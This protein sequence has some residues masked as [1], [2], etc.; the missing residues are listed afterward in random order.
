MPSSTTLKWVKLVAAT[1]LALWLAFV[2]RSASAQESM[3][4]E[5]PVDSALQIQELQD[6]LADNPYD[7]E[8]HT[9]LAILYAQEDLLEEAREQ[10]IAALQAAPQEPASHLN[11]GLIL[12][13]MERWDEAALTLENYARMTSVEARGHLLLGQAQAGAGNLEEARET[14]LSG[15]DTPGMAEDQRVQLVQ[16]AVRGYVDDEH[17]AQLAQTLEQRPE[18]LQSQSGA[19]LREMMAFASV[20]LARE[21]RAD[22]NVD[23]AL[24]E[25]A[26]ARQ[27]GDHSPPVYTQPLEL[28]LETDRIADA[29]ALV[30]EA[31]RDAPTPGMA[32]YLEGQVAEH[33]GD[34]SAARDAYQ[35]AAA[36]D[37]DL[38]GL[39]AALGTVLASLGDEKGARTA[40]LQAVERGEGG[41]AAQYNMGVVLSKE[42]RYSEAIPHLEQAIEG[43]PSLKDAYRALGNAY[44]KVDRYQDAVDIY[45]RLLQRFGPDPRD[46]YQ[47]A[48][49][50]AKVGR[51]EEAVEN[52]ELVVALD[53]DNYAARYNLGN[54]LMKLDRFEPAIEQF[55]NAV[56]LRPDNESAQYN[57]ALALQKAGRYEE[58]IEQY[59]RALELKETYRSYV[60]L[61]IC[62][63]EI[64]DIETSDMYYQ[65]ANELRGGGR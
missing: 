10:F 43:D 19:P 51:H 63:K 11:L 41:P 36:A 30:A 27:Y 14:W 9:K 22:G 26:R 35:Q 8:A 64:E 13:R 39:Q 50:L 48:Y 42:D 23:E 31:R 45:Q 38:P 28:M 2:A 37:A 3:E 32:P 49:N 18:L 52:Y 53:P 20:G 40:L 58:A 6:F 34:L 33:T 15:A 57:L 44:R 25:Y 4:G 12:M 46:H 55:Q 16:Q 24:K 60:N 5:P 62:Y 61:A 59:E 54:S 7:A 47:L 65:K 21:A 29:Q 56:S 17:Y 1:L